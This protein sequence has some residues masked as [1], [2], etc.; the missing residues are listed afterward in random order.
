MEF[1]Q[2]QI[3]AIRTAMIFLDKNWEDI[4]DTEEMES[5]RPIL[6]DVLGITA[7]IVTV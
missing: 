7:G 6:T 4:V 3:D 5:I 1:N 2:T